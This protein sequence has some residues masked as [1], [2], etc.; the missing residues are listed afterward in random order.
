MAASP[1]LRALGPADNARVE[2]D[3]LLRTPHKGDARRISFMSKETT[4]P[5]A[6]ATPPQLAAARWHQ[7]SPQVALSPRTRSR[8]SRTRSRLTVSPAAAELLECIL[9]AESEVRRLALVSQAEQAVRLLQAVARGRAA[10]A[11]TAASRQ[12]ARFEEYAGGGVRLG[13]GWVGRAG[14]NVEVGSEGNGVGCTCCRHQ[15]EHLH[16]HIYGGSHC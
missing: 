3:K 13:G 8:R 14:R 6:W 10:R 12:G 11:S 9:P 5:P 7:H 16:L 4:S 2:L 15:L 1:D